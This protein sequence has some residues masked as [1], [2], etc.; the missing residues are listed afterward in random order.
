MEPLHLHGCIYGGVKMSSI[1]KLCGYSVQCDNLSLLIIIP[2]CDFHM[3]HYVQM[4][5]HSGRLTQC[6]LMNMQVPV[7][8][9]F[10]RDQNEFLLATVHCKDVICYSIIGL[11]QRWSRRPCGI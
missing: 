8:M 4:V 2:L 10:K 1:G 6:M 5:E 9:F 7:V 11:G 3:N